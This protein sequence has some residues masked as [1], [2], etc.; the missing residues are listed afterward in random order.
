MKKAWYKE[1]VALFEKIK[2]EVN[3]VYPN[4]HFYIK[5][6]LVLVRGTFPILFEG[7]VLDRYVV[8]IELLRDYPKSI[9]IVR[10]VGGRIPRTQD[11]HV[12]ERGEACLFL[13]EECWRIYPTGTT[14][15]DFLK[16]PVHNFFLG[17]SLVRLGQPWPFG[18]WAHGSRGRLEYYIELI[19][20]CDSEAILRFLNFLSKP[21]IKGHWDC[22]CGSGKRLRNCHFDKLLDLRNKIEQELAK[23]SFVEIYKLLRK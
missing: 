14:F 11:Y 18:A 19:G 4:L 20:I 23:K 3:S 6:D 15:L 17:Q 5:N 1:D 8:E 9:P 7:R 10:E 13:P 12:N 21:Q 2:K 22:P 16:G